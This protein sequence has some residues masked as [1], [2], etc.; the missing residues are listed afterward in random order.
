V[1]DPR[2]QDRDDVLVDELRRVAE[3]ADPVPARVLDAA[4]GSFAWRTIDAELAA[5]AF[6]SATES[7]SEALV[8]SAGEGRFLTFES[9]VLAVEV[10]V[11]PVDSERRLV[12][13]L[14]PPQRAAIEIRHAGGVLAVEADELGRFSADGVASGPVALVCRVEG[15]AGPSTVVTDWLVI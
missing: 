15:E 5:L 3:L 13:Q 7:R 11:T 1:A 2:G 14:V 8:R 6:D 10:E 4:R 9:P 12:G